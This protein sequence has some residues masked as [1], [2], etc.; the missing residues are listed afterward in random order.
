MYKKE[1]NVGFLSCFILNVPK[2]K[3][4][5]FYLPKKNIKNNKNTQNTKK[6]KKFTIFKIPV[7]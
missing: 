5:T 3:K 1:K 7:P 2:K 6:K 4:K